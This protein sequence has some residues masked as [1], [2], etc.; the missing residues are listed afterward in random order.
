MSIQV[1][2]RAV[3]ADHEF[4]RRVGG[5][6]AAGRGLRVA[7]TLFAAS[8]SPVSAQLDFGVIGGLGRAGFT[9]SGAIEVMSRT[10][11]L[12][13]VM[14]DVPFGET[15]SIRPEFYVSSKG[16]E[17]NTTLGDYRLGPSKMFTLSYIQMPV[18]AQ[19]R[20]AQGGSVRPH[21]FGGVSVGVLLGCELQGRDCDDIAQIDYRAFDIGVVV[22]GEAEWRGLGIGARYEAGVR[23]VE[24]STLGNE[25][26]NGVLSFT[27][28]YMFRR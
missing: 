15:F 4:R 9:G 5:C 21:L 27:V 1:W 11:F 16:A 18:L 8:F 14:G 20:T 17:V 19:L 6:A 3:C 28:R 13:G 22:G 24:A 10:T 2:R 23:A 12:I 26:Y 25:I 7:V